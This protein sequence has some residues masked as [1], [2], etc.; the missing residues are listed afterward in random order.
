MKW[1]PELFQSIVLQMKD[2]LRIVRSA[3]LTPKRCSRSI[4]DRAPRIGEMREEVI[5]ELGFARALRRDRS[6]RR[7]TYHTTGDVRRV[8][9]YAVF[10]QGQTE[11]WRAVSVRWLRFRSTIPGPLYDEKH[12]RLPS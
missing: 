4:Y 10:V 3:L 2:T 6:F 9:E 8:T 1:L 5:T 12:D 7:Y 11:R